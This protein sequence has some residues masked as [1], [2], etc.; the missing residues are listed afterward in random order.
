ML[1]TGELGGDEHR[2][3]YSRVGAVCVRV[4]VSVCVCVTMKRC[5]KVGEIYTEYYRNT[6]I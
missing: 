6:E 4:C 3:A 1:G 2:G 5:G